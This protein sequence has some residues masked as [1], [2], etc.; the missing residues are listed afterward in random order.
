MPYPL[1]NV[2]VDN[3][4]YDDDRTLRFQVPV[5]S[6]F[7]AVFNQTVYMQVGR[8]EPG[9]RSDTAAY[10]T[11]EFMVPGAYTLNRGYLMGALRFR[12]ATTEDAQVTAR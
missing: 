4:E 6:A 10:L 3:D 12:R 9:M 1:N 5:D 8:V 11:E 2:T 7:V